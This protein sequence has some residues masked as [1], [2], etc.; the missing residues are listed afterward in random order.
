MERNWIGNEF[1][2]DMSGKDLKET[3]RN[4][5]S[6]VLARLGKGERKYAPLRKVMSDGQTVCLIILGGCIAVY[7]IE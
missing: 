2:T 7:R 3:K 6:E 4:Y 5:L 1:Y